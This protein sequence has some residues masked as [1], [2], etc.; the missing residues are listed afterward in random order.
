ME[1]WRCCKI[2]W[3]FRVEYCANTKLGQGL[4]YDKNY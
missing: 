1:G 2:A 4:V 3:T